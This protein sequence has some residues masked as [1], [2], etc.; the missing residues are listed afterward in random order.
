LEL[1]VGGGGLAL[2]TARSGF[3]H[4]AVIDS[5]DLSC[6]TLRRN[7]Q[8]NV[9]YVQDWEI[10]EANISELDF[11]E[12]SGI[13][14]L[15]GGP[16]CQPFSQAGARN[17]RSDNRDMFPDFI[18]AIRQCEPKSFIIENV[19]GL[20]NGSFFKYFGYLELQ[21]RFPHI[22]KKKGEKWTEHRARLERLYTSGKYQDIYYKVLPQSLN[23]A[24]FGAAQRRDRVFLVGIRADLG[25]EYSFPQ[26]SHTR[27][28]LWFDQWI[29]GDYWE[30]HCIPKRRRPKAPEAIEKKLPSLSRKP[31]TNAWRTVRDVISDLPNIGLGR[32][33]H[34]VLN[35]FLNPGARAYKGHVGSRMDAPA[36]TIKAGHNGVPG[37]E[38]MIQLDD[39]TLRYFSV[40][41]CARLQTFPDDWAFHGSWCR[42]MRQIGNAVPVMLAE[43]VANPLAEALSGELK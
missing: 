34:K 26:P 29:S 16:P 5:D 36:K 8:N 20:I 2:G 31:S 18:R 37:G 3:Q 42:S 15:S 21:L 30:R 24:D 25:I 19:K 43:V 4:A 13:D 22:Q 41:E 33:S 12:Y 7:K 10:V 11:S 40:R 32:T 39:G 14:M 35:H 6:E 28:G 1:C 27:E 23:A 38:N 17:G 9:Q